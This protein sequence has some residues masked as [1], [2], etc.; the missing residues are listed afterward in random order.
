M[1]SGGYNPQSRILK[2]TET[3]GEKILKKGGGSTSSFPLT[4]DQQRSIGK[5]LRPEKKPLKEAER[6][7]LE[8]FMAPP[9]KVKTVSHRVRRRIL[10]LLGIKIALD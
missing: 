1:G 7:F 3:P 6:Q 5:L 4:I 10:L 8:K 9:A 2:R